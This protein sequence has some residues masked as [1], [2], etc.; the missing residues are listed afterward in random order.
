MGNA[1]SRFRTGDLLRVDAGKG[2]AERLE[3]A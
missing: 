1:T 2:I 3:T